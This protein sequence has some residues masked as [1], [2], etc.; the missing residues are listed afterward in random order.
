MFRA[1]ETLIDPTELMLEL[2]KPMV[3]LLLPVA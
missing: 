1:S 2:I 3:G